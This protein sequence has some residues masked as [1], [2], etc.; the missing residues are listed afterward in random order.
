MPILNKSTE[1]YIKNIYK[2]QR[3]GE[4]VTTSALAM[5]LQLSDPSV[6]DM[7]KKLSEKG[8]VRYAPYRGVELTASGRL[9]A[10]KIVRRHR[11]WEMYLMKFLGFSW[12]K[13][14]DEAER[15]EH[16]TSEEMEQKLDEALGFPAADPHG[17]PIPDAT[18]G[19]EH[20]AYAA[21]HEFGV[22]DVVKVL[23]VSDDDSQILQHAT[24]LGLGLNKKLTVRE[25]MNF[26][27]SMVVKVGGKDQ[28]ISREVA[29]S[30]FVEL[31]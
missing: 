19:L 6:T 23:R 12:D 2:L 20:T 26:D 31:V 28:F 14:H 17:D 15:L 18:G 29:G 10:L 25:K 7:I 3:E 30:I 16:V 27:G 9:M 24:K 8:L 4:K 13:V 11:L 1:D 21:L 5:T 22:G